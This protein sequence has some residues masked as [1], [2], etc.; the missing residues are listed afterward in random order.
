MIA[1]NLKHL[2]LW[3]RLLL[4]LFYRISKNLFHI[5]TNR[6]WLLR[7]YPLCKECAVQ[8]VKV[9]VKSISQNRVEALVNAGSEICEVVVTWCLLL[10]TAKPR[11]AAFVA[12]HSTVARSSKWDQ[13]SNAGAGKSVEV[14]LKVVACSKKHRT[15]REQ[16]SILRTHQQSPVGLNP[17]RRLKPYLNRINLFPCSEVL[18][19]RML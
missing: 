6:K 3:K 14:V 1:S 10:S 13:G 19:N 16:H 9:S 18:V 7:T 12:S 5:L 8:S 11:C 17:D 15:T 4:F 2:R